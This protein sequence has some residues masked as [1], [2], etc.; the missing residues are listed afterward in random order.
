MCTLLSYNIEGSIFRATSSGP[1]LDAPMRRRRFSKEDKEADKHRQDLE[2]HPGAAAAHRP[3]SGVVL[4][5]SR[6]VQHVPSRPLHL[7]CTAWKSGTPPEWASASSRTSQVL[8]SCHR[9]EMSCMKQLKGTNLTVFFNYLSWV[10]RQVAVMI[11]S[12][13]NTLQAG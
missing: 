5:E 6:P 1:A 10:S 3:F 2:A 12:D 8:R 7:Y 4:A 11:N 13:E 9:A